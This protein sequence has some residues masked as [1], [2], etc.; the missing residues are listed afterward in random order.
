MW[1]YAI[2]NGYIKDIDK[3]LTQ[4]TERQ[5][6]S[7]NLSKMS[8]ADLKSETMKWLDILNKKFGN[9]KGDLIEQE[10]KKQLTK[11]NLEN[12]LKKMLYTTNYKR[13][14]NY[15]NQGELS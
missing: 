11:I 6:F 7:L 5:D 12:F 2:K 1:D 13:L 8:D 10:L 4:I 14:L 3:Y 15:A 9:I